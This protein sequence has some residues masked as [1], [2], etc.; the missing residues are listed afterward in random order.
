MKTITIKAVS[1]LF[2]LSFCSCSDVSDTAQIPEMA[3]TIV[4]QEPQN[5]KEAE[6]PA[7][8]LLQSAELVDSKKSKAPEFADHFLIETQDSFGD[9]NT[10]EVLTIEQSDFSQVIE[11]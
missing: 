10:G 11:P 8:T 9:L 7:K 6:T 1:A 4:P 5:P 3:P 2:I